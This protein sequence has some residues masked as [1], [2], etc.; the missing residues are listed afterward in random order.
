[1]ARSAEKNQ[2]L[3]GRPVA[4]CR[5][6]SEESLAESNPLAKLMVKDATDLL[7]FITLAS[8]ASAS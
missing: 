2:L 6:G 3:D 8:F 7:H 4:T 5:H 1:M